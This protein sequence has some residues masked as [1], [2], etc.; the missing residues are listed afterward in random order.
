M[1]QSK[2]EPPCGG[3]FLSADKPNYKQDFGMCLLAERFSEYEKNRR[4]VNCERL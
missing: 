2:S 4:N 1:G 3:C